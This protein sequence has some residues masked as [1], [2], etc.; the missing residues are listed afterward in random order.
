M[1]IIFFLNLWF[2]KGKLMYLTVCSTWYPVTGRYIGRIS[3]QI[4]IRLNPFLDLMVIFTSFPIYANNTII[5][6]SFSHTILFLTTGWPVKHSR[7]L[8][9]CKKWLAQCT[10]DKSLNFEC[11]RKHSHVKWL[12]CRT[13]RVGKARTNHVH[14]NGYLV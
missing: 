11:N 6:S 14:R 5:S 7:L 12:P 8:V 3:G 2:S 9:P 10:L 4:I 1:Y 13:K